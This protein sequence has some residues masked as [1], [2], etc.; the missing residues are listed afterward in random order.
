MNQGNYQRGGQ[1]RIVGRVAANNSEKTSDI[2]VNDGYFD[3]NGNKLHGFDAEYWINLT[4]I[5]SSYVTLSD[6]NAAYPSEKYDGVTPVKFEITA[7]E[8]GVKNSANYPEQLLYIYGM[9][10]MAD[11]GDM[12]NLYWQEFKI[13]GDA[14]KLTALRLGYDGLMTDPKGILVEADDS[15]TGNDVITYNGKKYY[16]WHNDK[17]NLPTI[18]SS[19]EDANGMP[20]LKEVNLSN[21]TINTGSPSINLKS[22]EKLED[23]RA[24]GSNFSTI[25]FAD[26][27]ALNTLYLPSS[28]TSLNLVEANLLTKLIKEYKY[29]VY[30]TKT[31][32]LE[33]EPGLYIQGLFDDAQQTNIQTLNLVG[34]SLGYG[35]YELL[36]KWFDCRLA[37]VNATPSGKP[38]SYLN[39]TKVNWCP[40]VQLVDGDTV[41][42][43]DL[44][45]YY[46]DNGHYGFTPYGS[47]YNKITVNAD[48]A[49]GIVYKK[50]SSIANSTISE[51]NDASME[52]FKELIDNNY[53]LGTNNNAAVPNIT[54]IVYVENTTPIEET[55]IRNTLGVK[56]PQL[57]FFF[58]NV[59]KAYTA[60]FI[61]EDENGVQSYVSFINTK[62]TEKSVQ[63]IESGWFTNPYTLYNPTKEAYDFHGWSTTND[64]TGLIA[65]ADST[66]EEKAIAWDNVVNQLAPNGITDRWNADGT[67][68]YDYV[69]YAVFTIHKWDI[70]FW[71]GTAENNMQA[72][73][74]IKATHGTVLSDLNYLVSYTDSSLGEYDRYRFLG[75]TQNI[76]NVVVT[77]ESSAKLINFA[78][79]TASGD[80]NFY[81][82]LMK[83]DVRTSVTDLKYFDFT[84]VTKDTARSAYKDGTEILLKAN[85]GYIISPKSGM[86]IAGK[87]TLPTTYNDK[88][89]V[90]VDGFKNQSKLTGVFWYG[91]DNLLEVYGDPNAGTGA[92]RQCENLT[93][94]QM[95]STVKLIGANAFMNCPKLN[96]ELQGC[97]Q[98][99]TIATQA[100]NGS[101]GGVSG[102]FIIPGSVREVG[103]STFSWMAGDYSSQDIYLG[104][105]G[106][107][108]QIAKL[109]QYAFFTPTLNS[110]SIYCAGGVPN[111]YVSSLFGSSSGGVNTLYVGNSS[112]DSK[113][114]VT[115][116][117]SSQS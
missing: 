36:K 24:T 61:I 29:P 55:Y 57:T 92:F 21:I 45:N 104:G 105:I 109:G 90:S 101:L 110:F 65:T 27:V 95:P 26:G 83:E 73:T 54:G 100:F 76:N 117:P 79:I 51:I 15:I 96:I 98:L 47:T 107:P 52:M 68:V 72:V 49:N 42:E 41:D 6:D 19:D 116:L 108:S 64:D 86:T 1:N 106:D 48:I 87:I 113:N 20:L 75:W 33:A 99:D 115:Y 7:I 102:T 38:T 22:C 53:F 59:N 14:T 43:S 67:H 89:V 35:S 37:V 4:P 8:N 11:L 44:D 62:I 16:R 84:L 103:I 56:F 12:S 97:K 70:N 40:Y 93:Y 88:P 94:F 78:S 31:S 60:K 32:K 80:M 69:F 81:A 28:I 112:D 30:N 25:S 111:S 74:T 66:E 23:F 9:N 82:V 5:R 2:W 114:S 13:E 63:K 17:M 39:M 50:D 77:N 85:S 46:L 71:V 3:A 18:P 58:A 34:G 10:Q 91:D